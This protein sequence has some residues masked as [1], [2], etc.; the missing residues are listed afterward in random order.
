LS[1]AHT[2][3][4]HLFRRK[5]GEILSALLHS[6]GYEHFAL[7]EE[8]VQTAFQRALEKWPFAGVP[9]NPSGWLYRV[10]RNAVLES[11]RRRSTETSRINQLATENKADDDHLRKEGGAVH[12]DNTSDD[13]ATMILLCCN[14]KISPK[15]QVCLTLKAACGFSVGEIARVLGMKDEAVK[16]TITRARESIASDPEVLAELSPARIADRFS[17]VMESLYAMFTEAYSASSGGEQLRR[18]VAEEAVYLSN[19]FLDSRLTP[20]GRKSE[21]HALIALMLFHIARFDARVGENG[22]PLRL[23]EQDRA[24]W[25]SAMVAAGLS[26]L[27][28]SKSSSRVTNFHI[29]AR[30]A[31][32]HSTSSSFA[33]THW[34]R[35]LDLYNQLLTLK[36]TPEVRLNRIVALRYAKGIELAW[37]ELRAFESAHRPGEIGPAGQ[38]FFFHA[39]K[40][41]FLE[42]AG[43]MREA[44]QEWKKSLDY[45]PTDADR[46]FVEQKISE[47]H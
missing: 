20:G 40:A 23:Q 27:E 30:I 42:S 32:E 4:E 47:H 21:L 12:R 44:L 14:P 3:T 8:A 10:A 22:I 38:S 26:A 5:Y 41:D 25:N 29:E 15:A 16:K 17:F 36:D 35:I 11:L 46:K 1:D 24:K 6:V 28:A 43:M 37:N 31:A 7:V 18:D 9:D 13:V 39:V 19:L 33:S 2:L 34:D 45:A